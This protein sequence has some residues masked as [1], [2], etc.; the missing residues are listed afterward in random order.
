MY[1]IA[2]TGYSIAK[3]GN[4]AMTRSFANCTPSLEAD[5]VKSYALAPSMTNTQLAMYAC[6]SMITR[7]TCVPVMHRKGF[8]TEG[9]GQTCAVRSSERRFGIEI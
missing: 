7:P 5:G 9:T 3:W 2:Q 4:I 1:D 8:R 6:H